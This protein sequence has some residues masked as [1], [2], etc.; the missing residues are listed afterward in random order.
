MRLI[1]ASI[2]S[3]LVV[4]VAAALMESPVGFVG[5]GIMGKGMAQNLLKK[6]VASK[7]VVWN[8]SPDASAELSAAFP[9]IVEVAATA[10]EVI[11]RCD[12]TFSMLSTQ[13]ASVAVFDCPAEAG[14]VV[15]SVT[16]GKCIVDC[17]TLS[18]ERMQSIAAAVE[19]RG[20][21]FLEAPV[22]GSK[23]PAETG[24][25]IF[26]CGGEQALY[27]KV[28]PALQAMGKANFLFGPVGGGSKMKLIVNGL[29]GT[30]MGAF[31]ESMALCSAADLP[32][33]LLLQ[34]LDL[35]AMANPMFKGKGP[36]M[37]NKTYA[38][39]FPLKHA[40]KD[41]RLALA[42]ASD[43]GVSLPTT[44]AANQQFLSVLDERGDE[45]FSAV[46]AA[47]AAKK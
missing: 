8:R 37:I 29:M 34:V 30:M 1:Y 13:E 43:L 32:Q 42:L 27:D 6:G 28:T 21:R 22:S 31:A 19:A 47:A 2:F 39:H 17:A 44:D 15:A 3:L 9:G 41:M 12:V 40:Q 18:P 11:Q 23:V 4:T 25:L 36:N 20:G 46:Y 16:P 33:D 10:G 38:P 5:L 24:T 35:G 45:D 14:G 26:L 7:L